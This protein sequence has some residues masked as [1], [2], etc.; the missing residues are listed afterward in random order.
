MAAMWRG[1]ALL[2]D[3]PSAASPDAGH[4]LFFD[5]FD[6]IGAGVSGMGFLHDSLPTPLLL[7]AGLLLWVVFAFRSFAAEVDFSAHFGELAFRR[8]AG[9]DGRVIP[10]PERRVMGQGEGGATTLVDPGTTTEH[11]DPLGARGSRAAR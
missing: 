4:L 6:A 2:R 10:H 7:L 8:L 3:I 1:R 11:R 9:V 5:V